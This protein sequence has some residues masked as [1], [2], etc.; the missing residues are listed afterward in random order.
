MKQFS[1]SDRKRKELC[2]NSASVY[3]PP[4]R[5]RTHERAQLVRA[6]V[7]TKEYMKE[8]LIIALLVGQP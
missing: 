2:N 5:D 4:M 7:K 3:G 6:A 1:L 8:T